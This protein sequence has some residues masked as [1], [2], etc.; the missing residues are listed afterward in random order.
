MLV[1]DTNIWV[2]AFTGKNSTAMQLVE[3]AVSGNTETV[4]DTYLYWEVINALG[5]SEVLSKREIT[6]AQDRFGE[7]VWGN[8]PSVQN[9]VD[10]GLITEYSDVNEIT[11][12]IEAI[13]ARRHNRM[14]GKICD[15]Q[16]KD[17]PIVALAFEFRAENPTIYTNDSGL[18]DLIPA[19]CNLPTITVEHVST[20][21]RRPETNFYGQHLP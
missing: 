19:N 12:G 6:K 18:A 17:A 8:V 9:A 21:D 16:P 2:Y 14:L 20:E 7:F 1:L 11:D 15:I 5:N 13:R 10:E 3:Q 4:V